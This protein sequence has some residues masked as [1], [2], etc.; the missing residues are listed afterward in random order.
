M[1][2]QHVLLSAG[3]CL[4]RSRW[5]RGCFEWQLQRLAR[6]PWL[7]E[8]PASSLMQTPPTYQIGA[9]QRPVRVAPELLLAGAVQVAQ[10]QGAGHGSLPPSQA[11]QRETQKA[12]PMVIVIGA[13]LSVSDALQRPERWKHAH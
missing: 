2:L 9:W 1:Q 5:L 8:M 13:V 12:R 7:N 11:A 3:G 10:Q 6:L 4:H